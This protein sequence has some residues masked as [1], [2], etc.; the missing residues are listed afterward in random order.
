MT[1]EPKWRP[2]A[3]SLTVLGAIA[4]LVPHPP[5][6][7]PV[8]AASVFAGARLPVW[9]AYLI[10]LAL[11]VITDPILALVYGVAPFTIYQVFI[12]ASFLISVW[13]G[14][15]VRNTGS[16]WKI[17][18]AVLLSSAQFFLISNLGSWI[19]DYPHTLAGLGSCYVAAIPFFE[20]TLVSDVFF[21]AALFGLYALLTRT[22]ASSERLPATA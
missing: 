10:P 20:R 19:K 9:Q 16:A 1:N 21:S 15:R 13:I 18:S 6:F 3:L 8:G 22:V 5:N 12:Y 11:M 7:A 2:V 4:R 17:G 14:R